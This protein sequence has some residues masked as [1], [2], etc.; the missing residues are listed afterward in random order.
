MK[1]YKIR[2]WSKLFENNRSRT[3]ERLAWVAIPNRHDGENYSAL[4]TS[5]DGAELFAAWCLIVQVASKCTPR[6][7]LLKGD[8]KPHDAGSLALKTRAP[9][10]WFEKCLSYLSANTDW[11]DV[12][13]IAEQT[14]GGCQAGD[15]RLS[16][17]CQ[18]G[19][20]EGRKGMDGMEGKEQNGNSASALSVS[21]EDSKPSSRFQP[22]TKAEL[23]F[24]AL[25]LGLPQSE[26]DKF[27]SFYE[28]NG[29]K[30]GQ[31]KMKS[32]HHAM[33]GWKSRWEEK[34]TNG[35]NSN[36]NKQSIDRNAGTANEGM[37]AQYEG[38]GRLPGI[39]YGSH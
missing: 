30:V 29:W 35:N 38:V 21:A 11:L 22:P 37:S 32:W 13:D 24:H 12:Q 9:E 39:Q 27:F 10:K 3:V 4:I 7:S 33:S 5:K 26:A 6:G 1:L 20:E 31:N 16:V 23:D 15:S 8:G 18:A 28:S 36:A 34:R 19:D 2:D 14:S 17:A 25:K